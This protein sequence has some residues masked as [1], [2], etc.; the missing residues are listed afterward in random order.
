MR[1]VSPSITRMSSAS[2]GAAMA[3]AESITSKNSVRRDMA[4]QLGRQAQDFKVQGGALPKPVT[5][6]CNRQVMPINSAQVESGEV[7]VK[8]CKAAHSLRHFSTFSR[9]QLH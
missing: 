2:I 1:I 6:W 9:L 4:D 5:P 3:G 8:D 7:N